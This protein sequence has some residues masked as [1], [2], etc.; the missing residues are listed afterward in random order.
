[1]K[2]VCQHLDQG[3]IH[4][5]QVKSESELAKSVRVLEAFY[6][7]KSV[8]NKVSSATIQ[9]CFNKICFQKNNDHPTLLEQN[10]ENNFPN[11]SARSM[12]LL[13]K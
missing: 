4:M 1:M 9:N 10:P 5:D 2:L 8:W 3:I 7:I 6:F 11:I 12:Q 13:K